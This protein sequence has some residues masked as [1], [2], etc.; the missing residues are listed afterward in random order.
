MTYSLIL[1]MG[2]QEDQELNTFSDSCI[3]SSRTAWATKDRHKTKVA[4]F[5]NRTGLG[6][7]GR[8]NIFHTYQT[9]NQQRH[10]N[11]IKRCMYQI[12][13]YAG[14]SWLYSHLVPVLCDITDDALSKYSQTGSRNQFWIL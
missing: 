9:T 8:R 3:V 2:K 6:K 14:V 1:E 12:W 10:S 7:I 5:K 4:V 13:L 11:K